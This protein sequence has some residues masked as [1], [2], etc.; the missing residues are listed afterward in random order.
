MGYTSG[1]MTLPLRPT[2][3][4]KDEMLLHYARL[5]QR[6]QVF[7]TLTGLTLA[8]F[9]QLVTDLLPAFAAAERQRL[10][11]PDR[12]R[13]IGA[14]RQFELA[15]RDQVLLTVIWLR[16][17]P[18][19]LVLGYLFGISHP[20]VGRVIGRVLP[21]LEAAGRATMRMPQPPKRQR[22]TLAELLTEF[23]DL[24]EV[25]TA[26]EAAGPLG[27]A[28]GPA[29]EPPAAPPPTA[30]VIVDTF[31]QRVQR[32]QDRTTADCHFSGKKKQ[33]TLKSQVMVCGRTGQVVDSADSVPGPRADLTVLDESGV[34]ARVPAG[35]GIDGD[36]AYVGI[37]KLHPQ[38][39]TPRRKPRGTP[40]PAADV[41]FNREF[42]RQRMVVEHTIRRMRCFQAITQ[43]DRHH[44]KHHSARVRAI[45]G[46]VN[47][48]LSHG[49]P[50]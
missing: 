3:C 20:T 50:C 34:L 43:M 30:R 35:V 44:R 10:S 13:A 22:R 41:V 14:G 32:P 38:G 46:L 12:Q 33:H 15:P 4:T 9:D 39:R 23:P 19:H 25:L 2:S 26:D 24:A 47:R 7:K 8:D 40:R 11:R 1:T 27:G 28:G 29:L 21:L 16:L 49:R 48:Q 45:G 18:L 17:Y 37:A 36:L 6:P 5:R 31:E 42:A